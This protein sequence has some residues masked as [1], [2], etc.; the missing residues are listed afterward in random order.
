MRFLAALAGA[1]SARIWLVDAPAA[2]FTSQMPIRNSP[3]KC[4]PGRARKARIAATV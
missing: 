2:L 1:R 3:D 4:L